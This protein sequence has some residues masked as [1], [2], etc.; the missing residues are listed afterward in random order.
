MW[1]LS[2]AVATFIVNA[3]YDV[4][5][6]KK[7]YSLG[8]GLADSSGPII[9]TLDN[10]IITYCICLLDLFLSMLSTSRTKKCIFYIKDIDKIFENYFFISK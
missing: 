7:S 8:P 9:L 3:C 4:V 5:N 1:G 2:V 10:D 6:T